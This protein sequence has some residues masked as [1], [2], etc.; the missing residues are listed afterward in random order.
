MASSINTNP[1]PHPEEGNDDDIGA[2]VGVK[3]A[4]TPTRA[5][6]A[7][8]TSPL[9]PPMSEAAVD[10]GEPAAEAQQSE[11]PPRRSRRSANAP[12]PE[13]TLIAE[14][15]GMRE[16]LYDAMHLLAAGKHIP[17]RKGPGQASGNEKKKWK[18]CKKACRSEFG[19][20]WRKVVLDLLS[21]FAACA[22]CVLAIVFRNDP[23][24]FSALLVSIGAVPH[25]AL[26]FDYFARC[27]SVCCQK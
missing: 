9:D 22:L 3:L 20:R 16:E 18:K 11:R 4:G 6:R 25:V 21:I 15:R 13:A 17:K 5:P 19:G 24:V 2:G 8:R 14:V 12:S 23:A 26:R 27:C 7:S 1:N 10:V